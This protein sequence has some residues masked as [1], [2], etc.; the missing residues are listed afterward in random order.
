MLQDTDLVYRVWGQVEMEV[1]VAAT[2]YCKG[3]YPLGHVEVGGG[4]RGRGS[5]GV[6]GIYDEARVG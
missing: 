6:K 1:V 5:N 3:G 4:G 2:H